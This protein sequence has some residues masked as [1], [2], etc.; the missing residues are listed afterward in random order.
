MSENKQVKL[1]KNIGLFGGVSL[2]INIIV[3]SG[4]F[5]SPKVLLYLLNESLII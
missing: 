1:E 4:I 2:I 5:V 3:G